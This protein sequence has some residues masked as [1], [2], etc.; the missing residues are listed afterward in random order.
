MARPD[1]SELQK[2]FL[3]DHATTG[4]SEIIGYSESGLQY[5]SR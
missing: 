1:W 2:Q 4:I 3:S 5:Q